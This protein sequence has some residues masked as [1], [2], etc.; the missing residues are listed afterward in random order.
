MADIVYDNVSLLLF[1]L[2][3]DEQLCTYANPIHA[4]MLVHA[5]T[6]RSIDTPLFC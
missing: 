1:K 2:K 4:C 5:R 6:H 3:L